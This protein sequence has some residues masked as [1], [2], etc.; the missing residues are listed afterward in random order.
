[1]TDDIYFMNEAIAEAELAAAADE[2]PVGAVVVRDGKIITAI[3]MGAALEFGLAL[4]EIFCGKETAEKLG[5]A[6][7]AK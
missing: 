3:G 2:V 4:V 7:L 1:M 6:V 5:G